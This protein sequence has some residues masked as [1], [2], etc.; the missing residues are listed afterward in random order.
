MAIYFLFPLV[1]NSSAPPAILQGSQPTS[2]RAALPQPPGSF[3]R[4]PGVLRRAA[5]SQFYSHPAVQPLLLSQAV[6]KKEF[7]T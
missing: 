5:A 4:V 3:R 7:Y 2:L 6:L 1:G